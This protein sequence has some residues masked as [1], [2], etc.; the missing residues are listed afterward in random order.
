MYL[1]HWPMKMILYVDIENIN[2]A[3][4]SEDDAQNVALVL[5]VGG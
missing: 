3:Q 2:K 5:R 4:L 1:S